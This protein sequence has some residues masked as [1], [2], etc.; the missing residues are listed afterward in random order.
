MNSFNTK[1]NESTEQTYKFW[2]YF[3]S[4]EMCVNLWFC[5]CKMQ[6]VSKTTKRER[7]FHTFICPSGVA[8][9]GLRDKT[10]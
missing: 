10:S 3:I 6:I 7:Y 9:T 8:K 2:M 4:L 5:Q 1:S